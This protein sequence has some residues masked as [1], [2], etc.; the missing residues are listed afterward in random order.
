MIEHLQIESI[1]LRNDIKDG[2]IRIAG[3]KKLKIYGQLNC[4]SGKKMKSENRVFFESEKEA[5]Y[6]GYRPC[7]SCMRE[8]YLKWKKNKM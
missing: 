2:S 8:E 4:K 6:L 7:G 5:L 3:N 1:R